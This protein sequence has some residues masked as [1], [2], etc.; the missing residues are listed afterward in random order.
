MVATSCPIGRVIERATMML[1]TLA[2]ARRT[3]KSAMTPRT[4]ARLVQ[5]GLNGGGE[6]RSQPVF[7]RLE[8]VDIFLS[9]LEP[10]GRCHALQ[11]FREWGIVD[12]I[13][14]ARQVVV[15]AL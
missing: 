6:V 11:R 13:A 7:E 2:I 3:T 15:T 5:R 8:H 14:H 1:R 10:L 4:P 12:N 9:D